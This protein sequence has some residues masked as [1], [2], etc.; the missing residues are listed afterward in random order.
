[1]MGTVKGTA[2]SLLK[3]YRRSIVKEQYPMLTPIS[4]WEWQAKGALGV[5]FMLHHICQKDPLGIPTNEDLKVSPAFLEKIIIQYREKGFDFIS[6]DELSRRLTSDRIPERPFVAFTMDDG[7]RDVYTNG[8][9]VIKKYNVP[10]CVFVATDF[11]D[12]KA[13]L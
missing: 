12:K 10:F 3:C 11:V 9:P 6:L 5:A 2:R 13:I 8:F 4:R 1:M 7:Y